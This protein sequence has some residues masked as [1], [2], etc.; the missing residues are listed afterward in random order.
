MPTNLEKI[1]KAKFYNNERL[2]CEMEIPEI[3][4]NYALPN[5]YNAQFLRN[6]AVTPEGH[7]V[8]DEKIFTPKITVTTYS[9]KEMD[10]DVAIYIV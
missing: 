4:E 6:K 3:K 9:F 8:D 5:K 7:I 1:M 10:G 2:V